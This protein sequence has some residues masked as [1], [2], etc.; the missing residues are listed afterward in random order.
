M[1]ILGSGAR[2]LS[3]TVLV[4]RRILSA[5]RSPLFVEP[6]VF[7]PPAVVDA[8][9]HDGQ[10]FDPG[11]PAGPAARVKDDWPRRIHSFRKIADPDRRR[12]SRSH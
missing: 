1:A 4:Q 9:D 5:Q 2:S 8:V 11:L 6:D 10:A 12:R 7:E 3:L